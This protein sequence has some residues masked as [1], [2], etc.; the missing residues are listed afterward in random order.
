MGQP[1]LASLSPNSSDPLRRGRCSGY[2]G[3][4]D[5]K[6]G[7]ATSYAS[8]FSKPE[9]PF[10]VRI[11]ADGYRMRQPIPSNGSDRVFATSILV[12]FIVGN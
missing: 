1:V 6:H 3:P 2:H 10:R 12:V 4:F 7:Q 8:V 11:E 9:A 5:S